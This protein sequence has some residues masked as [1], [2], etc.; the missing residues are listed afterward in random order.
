VR[1][2]HLLPFLLVAAMVLPAPL[3]A[4]A[5][6]G[7]EVQLPTNTR[8]TV[9]G[10]TV[11]PRNI[12]DD[13]AM[14]ELLMAGFPARLHFRVELWADG[15]LFDELQQTVEW[16]VIIQF[17]G[18]E[19]QYEVIQYVG[20]RPFALGTFAK[21]EDADAAASRPLRVPLS[22]PE[23]NRRFYYLATLEVVS[24]EA[25]DLDEVGRWLRGE[26]SPAVRGER[27]AGTALSRGLRAITTRLLGGERRE[28]SQRSPSFRPI[29]S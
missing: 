20:G 15:W 16:D 11:K 21:I 19:Q 5:R 2:R 18:V 14:R 26:L 4:Q 23:E 28:Y 25:S 10:P 6:P 27:S 1:A 13:I 9:E 8:L 7:L 3:A 17:R 29:A 24:M 12:L 22:A